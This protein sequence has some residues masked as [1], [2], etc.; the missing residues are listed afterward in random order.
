[1]QNEYDDEYDDTYRVIEQDKNA[2]DNREDMD[3][4]SDSEEELD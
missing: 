2:I 1:M 3:D 4:F